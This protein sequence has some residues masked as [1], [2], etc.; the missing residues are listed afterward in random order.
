MY[1]HVQCTFTCM[2]MYMYLY[3]TLICEELRLRTRALPEPVSNIPIGTL[4]ASLVPRPSIMRR[5]GLVSTA[6]ACARFSVY[7]AV[8]LTVNV[9]AHNIRTYSDSADF[10]ECSRMHMQLIPGLPSA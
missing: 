3:L 6:C 2:C 7:F 10:A 1:M 8:K 9:Q 5:E 4:M